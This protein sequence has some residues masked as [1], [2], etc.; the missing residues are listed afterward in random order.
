MLLKPRKP[1]LTKVSLNNSRGGA[2]KNCKQ[3]WSANRM[4]A[5]RIGVEV[6]N[7]EKK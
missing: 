1:I 2:C 5:A 3:K 7:G 4:L 6:K